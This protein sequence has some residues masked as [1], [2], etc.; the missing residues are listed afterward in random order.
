MLRKILHQEGA[1]E[2]VHGFSW[3]MSRVGTV[4]YSRTPIGRSLARQF[5][6]KEVFPPVCKLG[7]SVWNPIS[8]ET[9]H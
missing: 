3:L 6:S 7:E 5:V 2:W 4:S 8:D 1:T 9:R